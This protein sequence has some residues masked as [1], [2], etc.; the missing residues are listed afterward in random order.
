[1]N[2]RYLPSLEREDSE[3]HTCVPCPTCQY[4]CVVNMSF[5]VDDGRMVDLAICAN[6]ADHRTIR[7][8]RKVTR[9]EWNEMADAGIP[10][11]EIR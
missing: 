7:A 3:E 11:V 8:F 5:L 6:C 10:I 2:P 9:A 1:M 4:K